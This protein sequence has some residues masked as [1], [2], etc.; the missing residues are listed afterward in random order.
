MALSFTCTPQ[1][2]KDLFFRDFNYNAILWVPATYNTGDQ[3]FYS[4]AVR[5]Y[6]AIQDGATSVPTTIADW[7]QIPD[8]NFVLDEDINKAITEASVN[9]NEGLFSDDDQKKT[10]FLYLV[11]HY[12]VVDLTAAKNAG[13]SGTSGVLTS[14]SVG[15][16]SESYTIPKWITDNP[17]LSL[18]ATTSYGIKYVSLI[19]PGLV[20]NIGIAQGATT[21]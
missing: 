8:N 5:F 14:R 9:F 1:D 6:E 12:L 16:V 20:G 13:Q 19:R 3:V 4:V 18:Y 15:N 11:A 17:I 2:F 21:P 10:T 7:K